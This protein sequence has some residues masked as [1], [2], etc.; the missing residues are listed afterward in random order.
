MGGRNSSSRQPPFTVGRC[1]N[2]SPNYVYL[3]VVVTQLPL[4]IEYHEV[5]TGL[6]TKSPSDVVTGDLASHTLVA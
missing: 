3:G 2:Y 1:D 5:T 4:R 6:H